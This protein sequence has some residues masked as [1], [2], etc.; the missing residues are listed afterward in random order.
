M[1]KRS[2]K[3]WW[4]K[5]AFK[6]KAL[7]ILNLFLWFFVLVGFYALKTELMEARTIEKQVEPQIL[8]ALPEPLPKDV[9]ETLDFYTDLFG[10]SKELVYK[11]VQ[12]ESQFSTDRIG[13]THLKNH[14]YGLWQFQKATFNE[15]AKKYK[16]KNADINDFRHQ[17]IVATQMIR[18]GWIGR[19]SCYWLVV[20][21]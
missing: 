7:F 12:C 3:I 20:D 2:I 8:P 10:V 4:T 13:D 1:T 16:L 6:I 18:D 14:S 17:T 5:R 11:I 9:I 15:F 21:K 19:W